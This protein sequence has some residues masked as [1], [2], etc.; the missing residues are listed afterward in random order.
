MPLMDAMASSSLHTLAHFNPPDLSSTAWSLSKVG[1]DNTPLRDAIAASSVINIKY[2]TAQQ[3][4]NIS[5]A[6]A[7]KIVHHNPLLKSTAS[8]LLSMCS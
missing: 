2:F 1:I 4:A 7:Q 5:W 3:L 8:A 6:I